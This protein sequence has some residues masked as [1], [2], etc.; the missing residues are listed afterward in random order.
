MSSSLTVMTDD[1]H[2]DSTFVT[3]VTVHI[4]GC[5]APLPSGSIM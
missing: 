4:E 1:R 5:H 3:H 2:A